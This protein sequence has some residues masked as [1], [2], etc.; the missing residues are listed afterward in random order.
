MSE[1]I[2]DFFPVARRSVRTPAYLKE[3]DTRGAAKP[4][5]KPRVPKK[6][7]PRVVK[8]PSPSPSVVSSVSSVSLVSSVSSVSFDGAGRNRHTGGKIKFK[9]LHSDH[10]IQKMV[11]G[12]I[13]RVRTSQGCY[14][15][16]D[17]R[18]EA[19]HFAN[20]LDYFNQK[21]EF[22]ELAFDKDDDLIEAL[23]EF[24]DDNEANTPTP[25]PPPLP[26]PLKPCKPYAR[27]LPPLPPQEQPLPMNTTS[28]K[29]MC[30]ERIDDIDDTPRSPRSPIQSHR[31][32]V[33][34]RFPLNR[35]LSFSF[36]ARQRSVRM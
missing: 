5:R 35:P 25:R 27:R 15:L 22:P 20:Q 13:Y 19:F 36:K 18:A 32:R 23:F 6:K 11:N 26:F 30:D 33:H 29:L 3:F 31:L 7:N 17:N 14:R 24:V 12:E 2:D 10:R 28:A 4:P 1:K 34:C 9:N 8:A 16:F 21:Q